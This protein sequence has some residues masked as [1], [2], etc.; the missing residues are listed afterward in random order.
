LAGAADA[1]DLAGYALSAVVKEYRHV[2][3][4][5]TTAPGARGLVD[6]DL[7]AELRRLLHGGSL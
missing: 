6:D 5:L 7:D 2:L 1:P 4:E 3:A